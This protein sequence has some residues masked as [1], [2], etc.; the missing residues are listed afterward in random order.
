MGSSAIPRHTDAVVIGGG[1]MGASTAF[2]LAR[3]GLDV[4][5]VEKHHIGSGATGH[6]GAIVRQHYE[7]RVGI[8]LARD[9]LAFF[10]RFEGETGLPCDFRRTGFLSGSRERDLPA[11]E[12]LLELLR[13]EGVG[14]ERLG[15]EEATEMEPQ[16]DVSDYAALVHDPDAG[17]AD[18]IATAA[19]FAEAAGRSGAAVLEGR[20]AR[21]IVIRKGRVAGVRLPGDGTIA[22]ERVVLAAGNWTPA[23]ARGAGVRL[24]VR[25]VRGE[26]AILRRPPG[27]GAPP[28]IH[29]D[30]YADTY[31]R[32][33]AEKDVLVGYM[34]TDPRKAVR[35]PELRDNSIAAATV[36]DLKARLGRRFPIMAR[37]QPRGGWSGLYDVTPDAYPIVD[38]VGPEGLFVAVGFS[39][40]GFKLC[41]EVGRLLAEF[42]ASGRRPEA[43]DALRASRYRERKPVVPDAPFP[44][45]RRR[46]P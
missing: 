34:D 36:R 26:V 8:R 6:S 27:F 7:S 31:S 16:L 18:P 1:C 12:A 39:G 21:E 46:L 5:L 20:G 9:S 14:A 2:H 32:P 30:F 28:R 19:G 38:S 44:A 17:Y 42:A 10:S 43:L 40:H 45:R 15:P 29:F 4:V 33:E 11:F 25:F 22:S 35:G 37:A 23:I 24:P 13:S 41:P 3:Q